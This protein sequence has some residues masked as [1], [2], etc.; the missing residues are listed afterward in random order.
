MNT[1]MKSILLSI[2]SLTLVSCSSMRSIGLFCPSSNDKTACAG[3][4]NVKCDLSKA[5]YN[6][7]SF[8]KEEQKYSN[9]QIISSHY[10]EPL[11]M[12]FEKQE[13]KSYY[14]SGGYEDG[15]IQVG[16][17][18]LSYLESCKN[19]PGKLAIVMDIDETSLSDYQ[20]EEEMGFE[21]KADIFNK[22][23]SEEKG[24]A[25]KPSLTLFNQAK[26]QGIAVFFI[27]GRPESQ[28]EVTIGNL[29][30]AGYKDWTKLIMQPND[31]QK[32]GSMSIFKT[33]ARKEIEEKNGYRIILNIGDQYS[34]LTGGYADK[35]F[36][37]PNP[38][39]Y[40]P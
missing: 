12:Y 5:C 11:N 22:F 35:C 16:E 38:F 19:T 29:E 14:K 21:F 4:D 37:Y 20:V 24:V 34:D 36:K 25:I 9:S 8:P 40:I 17:K 28:R 10:N 39:Y 3:S 27:T 26:K 32:V 2:I 30:K 1:I 15:L 13:L 31:A 33:A 18:A 7:N 6:K 23:V